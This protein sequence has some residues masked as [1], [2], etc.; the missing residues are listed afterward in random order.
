M[1]AD[2]ALRLNVLLTAGGHE[3][4][5]TAKPDSKFGVDLNQ[6]PEI[7]SWLKG[8]EFI[9][10]KGIATHIGSQIEDIAIFESMAK[11]MGGLYKDLSAQGQRLERLD[12]GGGLGI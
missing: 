4:V 5:Q 11:K 8:A 10:L 9:R 1:H 3:H 6:L 2:V 7:L 12:L